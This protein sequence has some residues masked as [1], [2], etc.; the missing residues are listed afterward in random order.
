M[1]VDR[2]IG[3]S[4]C[5]K[6]CALVGDEIPDDV[7]ASAIMLCPWC[8]AALRPGAFAAWAREQARPAGGVV[9]IER[10]D[11]TREI[12]TLTPRPGGA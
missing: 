2:V 12:L 6:P 4:R 1:R 8:L 5:A 7:I 9:E 10:M 3:C 11:G